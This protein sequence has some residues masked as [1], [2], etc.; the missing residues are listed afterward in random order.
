[1]E[2]NMSSSSKIIDGSKTDI[3]YHL[4]MHQSSSSK[5]IDGSKTSL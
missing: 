4:L 5:I 3:S 1:M 2:I